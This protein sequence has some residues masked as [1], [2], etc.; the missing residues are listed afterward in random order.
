MLASLYPRA[1]LG[2]FAATSTGAVDGDPTALLDVDTALGHRDTHQL[3]PAALA[4]DGAQV[5]GLLPR[6]FAGEAVAAPTPR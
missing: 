1:D 6:V 2:W 5:R 4:W 3:Y